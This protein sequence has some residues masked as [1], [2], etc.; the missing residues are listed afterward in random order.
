MA[1]EIFEFF[2]QEKLEKLL[3]FQ[4]IGI[5]TFHS[6][7]T[8]KFPRIRGAFNGSKNRLYLISSFSSILAL[9]TILFRRNGYTFTGKTRENFHLQYIL[10]SIFTRYKH[11][12]SIPFSRTLAYFSVMLQIIIIF[13][14]FFMDFIL[15]SLTK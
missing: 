3:D 7:E 4:T 2:L 6:L 5:K 15:S 9:Q 11:L 13:N 1:T 8:S 12:F 10:P 14:F